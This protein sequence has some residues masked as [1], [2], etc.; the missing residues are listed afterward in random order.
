MSSHTDTSGRIRT[1][2]RAKRACEMCKLRKR[3]CDGHEPC[4]CCIRYEYHCAFKPSPREKK[5]ISKSSTAL[6]DEPDAQ[7]LSDRAGANQAHMEANS[8]TAFPHLL[9]M[10]LNPQSAPNVHGFSWNLGPRDEPLELSTNMTGLIS[11]EEMEELASHYLKKI[12]PVYGVLDPEDLQQ[13]IDTRWNDSTTV[14]SYDSILCGV[15][16]LGSLYSGHKQHPKESALVQCAKEKLETTRTSKTT[17]LHYASTWILRTIC[18][19]STNCPHASWMASCSTMHIIEA[20]GAHQEPELA[21]LVC[22][23]TA[24]VSFNEETRRWLFWVATVLN[25]WISYEYGRSR[26]TPR[27]VSCKLPLPRKDDFTTDLISCIKSP[28]GSIQTVTIKLLPSKS[29]CPALRALHSPMML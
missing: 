7:R 15:A 22:S 5:T 3:K 23:D 9:G 13:K 14:A 26:V 21:S 10:I 27:G 28:N 4:T 11:K 16:A 29:L 17:L 20:I 25:S 1:R 24:D 18:L 19:R 12:H 8:G 2:Q 6:G